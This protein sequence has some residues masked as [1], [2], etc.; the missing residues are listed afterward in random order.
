VDVIK[1]LVA[2]VL[3]FVCVLSLVDFFYRGLVGASPWWGSTAGTWEATGS[4]AWSATLSTVHLHLC[5]KKCTVRVT[6]L[7][8]TERKKE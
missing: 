2:K 4:T 6:T 1:T 7:S 3:F 5:S 8:Q